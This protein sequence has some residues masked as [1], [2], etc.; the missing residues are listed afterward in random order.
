MDTETTEEKQTKNNN[1]KQKQ[2]AQPKFYISLSPFN[3]P[4]VAWK[5]GA[6]PEHLRNC[7]LS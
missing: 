5:K 3:C 2:T 7:I 6:F 1:N 4:S